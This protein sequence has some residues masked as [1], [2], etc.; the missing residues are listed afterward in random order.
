MLSWLVYSL[1]IEVTGPVSVVHGLDAEKTIEAEYD[2]W[3]RHGVASARVVKPCCL[4][5]DTH[6][7]SNRE[8]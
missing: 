2:R 4:M 8:C 5:I 3:V 6:A 7:D 1:P